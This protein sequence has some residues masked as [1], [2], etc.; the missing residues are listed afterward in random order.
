MNKCVDRICAICGSQNCSILKTF[1]AKKDKTYNIVRC[2]DCG[3]VYV[4]NPD[5]D[6]ESHGKEPIEAPI[7]Q[8]HY[9][10]KNLIFN[11]CVMRNKDLSNTTILEIGAGWGGLGYLL[12]SEFSDS[13]SIWGGYLGYEPSKIR[14]DF[15]KKNGLNVENGYFD[16]LDS[17]SEK[18]DFVVLDNVLEHVLEP[19]KMIESILPI[20]EDNGRLIIILPNLYDLRRFL[21]SWRKRHYWQPTC[22]I[23]YFS[24]SSLSKL[25][26]KYGL[27]AIG[28]DK[29][30]NFSKISFSWRLKFLIDRYFYCSGLYVVANKTCSCTPHQRES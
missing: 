25:L 19:G 20:M 10:I 21:P 22:H 23:N 29:F 15:C 18:K 27:Y 1:P 5:F 9:F 8:R 30:L 11:D 2:V 14:A 6:T 4:S 13:N 3:F 7:S 28:F 26:L 24:F 12:T 17:V 16:G